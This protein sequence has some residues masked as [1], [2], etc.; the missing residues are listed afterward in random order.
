MRRMWL[1]ALCC[2]FGYKLASQAFGLM[3]LH[4]RSAIS[5]ASYLAVVTLQYHKQY[6]VDK[7]AR[8]WSDT[9]QH[10]WNTLCALHANF[11]GKLWWR[12]TDKNICQSQLNMHKV[13]SRTAC[14]WNNIVL[15]W[16]VTIENVNKPVDMPKVSCTRQLYAG[17]LDCRLPVSVYTYDDRWLFFVHV[18]CWPMAMVW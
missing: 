5:H 18:L 15:A 1:I 8:E 10:C 7:L 16:N 11:D 17:L 9:P 14:I 4:W 6:T 3:L 13:Q 2:R 12:T